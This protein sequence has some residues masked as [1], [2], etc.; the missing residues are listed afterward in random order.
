MY[1]GLQGAGADDAWY[2]MSLEVEHAMLY[3]LALLV[4][5]QTSIN[6]STKLL[7]V[8]FMPYCP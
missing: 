1:G 2:S 5:S 3:N 4:L 7:V 8:Y 6:A